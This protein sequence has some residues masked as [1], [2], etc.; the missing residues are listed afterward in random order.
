MRT[1]I[2]LCG[3]TVTLTYVDSNTDE[4]V[5]R[6]FFVPN[7]GGYVREHDAAGRYPQVCEL[8]SSRGNTLQAGSPQALL[9]LVRRE[10]RR[11]REA[12]RREWRR[13]RNGR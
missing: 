8:L 5:T 7:G 12:G 10:W 4:Q 2:T 3:N 6:E 1:T 13:F 11:G 9:E